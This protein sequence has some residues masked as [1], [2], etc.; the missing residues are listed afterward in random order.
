MSRNSRILWTEGLFL[1]PQHFQQHDRYLEGYVEG[2]VSALGANGWGFHGLQLESDLLALGKVGLRSAVGVFPD[3]T[4]FAMPDQEPLPAP[5]EVDES[6]RDR[7]VLLALPLRGDGAVE[8]QRGSGGDG[9][10]RYRAEDVEVR[11]SVL[12][13]AAA[14]MVEVGRLNARL[15]LEGEALEEYACIPLARVVERRADGQVI[16]DEEFIP[17]VTRAGAARRLESF[18]NELRGTLEQRADYLAERV[19]TGGGAGEVTD[20]LMLQVI[21]R[22]A[23]VMAHLA[24]SLHVHPERL[25]THLLAMAGE[26]ATMTRESRRPPELATYRHDA[27]ADAFGPLFELLRSEFRAVREAPAELIPLEATGRHGIRVARIEDRS[28][29]D[30]ANFVLAVGA[31]LPAEEV[32]RR[33]PAQAKLGPVERIA[34]LVNNNLPGVELVPVPVAPRQIPYY[35]NSVYF[36]LERSGP[37]WQQ[38]VSSGGLAV[39][40]AGQFPDLK[41]DLWAIRGQRR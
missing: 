40:V 35:A 31:S 7:T 26:L 15:A 1:E 21:N 11:D 14:T 17:T 18:I 25:Y 38:V 5:L 19:T 12:D 29:L 37:L 30:N 6:V 8:V 10:Y 28:L 3:G 22:H 33:F 4:P 27:L 36:E 34:E 39:H 24:G 41:M 13:S 9:L 32:R 23:P 16:L 2:R 20:F